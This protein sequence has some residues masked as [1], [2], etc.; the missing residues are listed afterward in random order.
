MSS[1]RTRIPVLRFGG[2]RNAEYHTHFVSHACIGQFLAHLPEFV[3]EAKWTCLL[4]ETKQ[5]LG[6][7]EL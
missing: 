5:L 2:L 6:A 3:S 1:T 4:K 7:F